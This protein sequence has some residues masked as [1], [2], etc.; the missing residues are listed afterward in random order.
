ML[1]PF[2]FE[3][4]GVMENQSELKWRFRFCANVYQVS[5]FLGSMPMLISK[6][7][8]WS[9]PMLILEGFSVWG[10]GIR[11]NGLGFRAL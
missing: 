6:A 4:L 3:G 10:S 11:V 5:C 8:F 1:S 2:R 7:M 9:K